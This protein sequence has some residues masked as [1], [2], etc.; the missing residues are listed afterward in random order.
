MN[1]IPIIIAKTGI[2]FWIVP[3]NENE[4]KLEK[5]TIAVNIGIV[6]I[7][8]KIIY[9]ILNEIAGI[10]IAPKSATYTIPHGKKPFNNPIVNN[11]L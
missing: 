5:Y 8:N 2:A 10:A 4:N 1:N 3:L 6:P 7:P 9:K 11:D